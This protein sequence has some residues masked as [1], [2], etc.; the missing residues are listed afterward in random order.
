MS[1]FYKAHKDMI[2]RKDLSDSE[3]MLIMVIQGLSEKQGYCFAT[4]AKLSNMVGWSVDKLRNNLRTLVEKGIVAYELEDGNRRKITLPEGGVQ[5]YT[6]GGVQNDTGGCEELH[7]GVCKS[8]QGGVQNHTPL[9]NR[10]SNR[11]SNRKVN[12]ESSA[13]AVVFPWDS[14]SFRDT[15]DIW[16]KFRTTELGKRNYKPIGEQAALKK[17]CEMASGDETTA[18]KIIEQSI[19]NSWQGL[20]PLKNHNYGAK[21]SPHDITPDEFSESIRKGVAEWNRRHG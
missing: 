7:R 2:E 19:S 5:F 6:E 20:F 10:T 13:E 18:R 17:L 15:W 21:K 11:T 16:R 3:K 12:R 4:N 1:Q 14:D 9:H 8:A